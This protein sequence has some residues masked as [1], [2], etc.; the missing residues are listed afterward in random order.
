V[1]FRN[2]IL[3]WI[4]A[5]LVVCAVESAIYA[6]YRPSIVERND[7]LVQP[8]QSFLAVRA[9]RWIIWNKVRKMPEESPIAVQAG[10]SSGFYGIMPDVVSEYIGARQLLNLS[11]C[12][13]QG[14]RGYLLLLELALQKYRSL[15]YT[16]V[17]VSP[18]VTLDESQWILNP[19]DTFLAPG[20]FLPM[21]GAAMQSNFI[22]YRK[23]LYPPSNAF[24]PNVYERIMLRN[25][26]QPVPPQDREPNEVF[27][28]SDGIYARNG[29]MIEHDLQADIVGGCVPAPLRR[30][31]A[32]GKTYWELFAEEF[33][34]LAKKYGVTP[35]IIFGPTSFAACD[36][37]REF[38][39]EIARLRQAFPSLK[40]P[41][42]PL[43]TWPN[44]FF[45]VPAH[46]QR[47]LA[48]EASRRVGRALRALEQGNEQAE[49][50]K[51][52]V[53]P[54][55]EPHIRVIGATLTE[56]CGW[57][58]DYKAGYYGDISEAIRAACDGKS[59]CTYRE[60]SDARDRLPPQSSCKGV[61]IV[62]YHCD[63]QPVR[64]FRQEGRQGFG[65]NIHIDCRQ[66]TYLARDAM[67]YGIQVA[68]ATFGN[69]SAGV[70]GNATTP[71]AIRCQGLFDC[72]FRVDVTKLG[73]SPGDSGKSLEIVYRCDRELVTRVVTID[74]AETGR[75]VHFGCRAPSSPVQ[76]AI[77]VASVTFGSECGALR[78][79]GDYAVA[80][81]CDGKATCDLAPMK[82]KLSAVVPSCATELDVQYRCGSSK[83]LKTTKVLNDNGTANALVCQA[84]DRN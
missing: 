3:P 36:A 2:F 29:Y 83:D 54:D 79:N 51:I 41:Y 19:P 14:F 35:V 15:S 6:A 34:A 1:T 84:A 18:T 43:E 12:A 42:D 49:D 5:A 26:V 67:P 22:G 25:K 27:A 59:A 75:L 77:S 16:I 8:I 37:N 32:S 69:S 73:G 72:L 13:N 74:D 23:Y 44:N 33:V 7:F 66:T 4:L 17:Y 47:S 81:L 70:V 28:R 10:D 60:G 21:L 57:A 56:E 58:P 78:G 45:S 48:V 40:I 64:S 11:C 9:E 80:T 38:Q 76:E 68:Y 46:V 62:D 50:L 31:P 39:D 53:A 61:Y 71:V 30:D 63:G 65:G 82:T 52:G 20:V 55:A 24:R